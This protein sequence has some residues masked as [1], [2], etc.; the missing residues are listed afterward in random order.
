MTA[1]AHPTARFRVYCR[2][3]GI[4]PEHARPGSDYVAWIRAR[5]REF[6]SHAASDGEAFVAWLAGAGRMSTTTRVPCGEANPARAPP[7]GT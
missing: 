2:V 5:R 6:G 4:D 7:G 1:N 3:H